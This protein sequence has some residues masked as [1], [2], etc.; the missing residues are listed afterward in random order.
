[1]HVDEL[2]AGCKAGSRSHFSELY[3]TYAPV[4]YGI[5]YRYSGSAEEAQDLLQ[6]GFINVFMQLKSFDGSKGTFEG[7]MKRIFVHK[8]ID[9]F[10]KR[11]MAL[12]LYPL[13]VA[14]N[15]PDEEE[16]EESHIDLSQTELL[17]MIR[18]LPVGYRTVLN[19]HVIEEKN[20]KEIAE[21]LVISE[22]TSKTQFMKARKM[23]QEKIKQFMG[24]DTRAKMKKRRVG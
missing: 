14:V 24:I 15:D 7:W 21:L 22:S 5:C 2:I 13:E 8:A 4:M 17:E 19:L 11:T 16:D 12:N 1:M 23:L 20:H 10:R 6:E 3:E 18:E 9:F